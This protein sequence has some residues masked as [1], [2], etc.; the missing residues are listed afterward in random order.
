VSFCLSY[1]V[2]HS[3]PQWTLI[4]IF[5][6]LLHSLRSLQGLRSTESLRAWLFNPSYMF[7]SNGEGPVAFTYP[8]AWSASAIPV[9]S[10]WRKPRLSPDPLSRRSRVVSTPP[11][12]VRRPRFWATRGQ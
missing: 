9:H 2:T 6:A 8:D 3:G 4:N 12:I 10:G 1:D 5:A 7:P 11:A